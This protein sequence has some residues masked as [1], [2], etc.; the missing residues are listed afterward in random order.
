MKLKMPTEFRIK[1]QLMK[2]LLNNY[3]R[4][5]TKSLFFEAIQARVLFKMEKI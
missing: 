5:Q 4:S 2:S 3:L 1:C